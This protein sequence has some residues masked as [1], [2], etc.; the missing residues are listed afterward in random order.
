MAWRRKLKSSS[1]LITPRVLFQGLNSSCIWTDI[2]IPRLA[3]RI[4]KRKRKRKRRGS[5]WND[6][7]YLLGWQLS[8]LRLSFDLKTHSRRWKANFSLSVYLT[9]RIL[10]GSRGST[11]VY[12]RRYTVYFYIRTSMSVTHLLPFVSAPCTLYGPHLHTLFAMY[13][14][15][16][17][18]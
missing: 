8:T 2:V 6:Q 18:F 5:V 12:R 1:V 9:S 7:T 16:G 10:H 3:V 11:S 13:P 4:R 17:G 14:C 15:L